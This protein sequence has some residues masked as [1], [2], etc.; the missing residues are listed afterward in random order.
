M[1]PRHDRDQHSQDGE[2]RAPREECEA[3][4]VNRHTEQEQPAVA[5]AVLGYDDG[6]DLALVPTPQVLPYPRPARDDLFDPG[7]L[8]HPG[9]GLRLKPLLHHL[10]HRPSSPSALP[11]ACPSPSWPICSTRSRTASSVT[12][13]RISSILSAFSSST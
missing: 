2:R 11:S 13:C 5:P 7:K 6:Y 3:E 8:L 1:A 9:D 12:D 10:G 4:H